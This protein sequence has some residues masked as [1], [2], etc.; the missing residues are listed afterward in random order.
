MPINLLSLGPKHPHGRRKF[1]GQKTGR[2]F[3]TRS[4]RGLAS[5]RGRL[6]EPL[7]G[8]PENGEAPEM[9]EVSLL[10]LEP[11]LHLVDLAVIQVFQPAHLPLLQ[12]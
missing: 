10:A 8:S 7:P 12:D 1:G 11:L 3:S 6:G 9:R 5:R 2:I 4:G